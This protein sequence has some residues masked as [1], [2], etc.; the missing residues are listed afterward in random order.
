MT[1]QDYA[2]DIRKRGFNCAQAVLAA[3]ADMHGAMDEEALLALAGGLGGGVRQGEVCG[4]VSGAVIT[5]GLMFPFNDGTDGASRA[6]IS[7]KSRE[8]SDKFKARFVALACSALLGVDMSQPDGLKTAIE[9]GASVR[10][11]D[12]I[13]GAIEI[14]EGIF[15]GENN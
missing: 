12:Y 8:F 2:K 3:A 1:R 11:A 5:L 15:E 14:L 13:S 4:A 9:T 6:K 7:E 10:C